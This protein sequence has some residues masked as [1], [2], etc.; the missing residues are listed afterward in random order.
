MAPKPEHEGRVWRGGTIGSTSCA[1]NGEGERERAES[2]GDGRPKLPNRPVAAGL[3]PKPKLKP[4]PGL[5][6]YRPTS[7]SRLTRWCFLRD[8]GPSAPESVAP[9]RDENA[10]GCPARSGAAGGLGEVLP[11]IPPIPPRSLAASQ[12][13]RP[14]R[15]PIVDDDRAR[16]DVT[17]AAAITLEEHE[18][19]Q[20]RGDQDED[21]ERTAQGRL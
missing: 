18:D 13:S 17:D 9:G 15:Q 1:A 3:G 8:T 4:S 2:L 16:G 6:D 12:P 14:P 7:Q 20:D 10:Q 5:C 11:A 21:L 19:A